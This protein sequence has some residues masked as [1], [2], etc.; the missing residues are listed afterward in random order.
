M[1]FAFRNGRPL[2]IRT[3]VDKAAIMLFHTDRSES[4]AV[5]FDCKRSLAPIDGTPEDWI[6]GMDRYYESLNGAPGRAPGPTPGRGQVSRSRIASRPSRR[7]RASSRP[8]P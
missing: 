7:P 4:E 3:Q 8:H 6:A 1:R 5:I 2:V